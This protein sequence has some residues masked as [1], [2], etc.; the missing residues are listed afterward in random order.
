MIV[1]LYIVLV[2]LVLRFSV[3]LFNFMSNPKLGNYKRKFTDKVSIIIRV[4]EHREE[5]KVL[6][7]SI[8]DQDYENIEILVEYPGSGEKSVAKA[9][10][11]YFLFLDPDT[12]LKDGFIHSLV[13]RT[14]IFNLALLSIVP[15]R[16]MSGFLAFCTYPIGDFVLLNLFPLRLVRL[17]NQPAF[18]AADEACL[19]FEARIYRKYE[20]HQQLKGLG[21]PAMEIVRL[22]KQEQLKAELLL[23]NRLIYI[24]EKAVKTHLVLFSKNLMQNFGHYPMVALIY[25]VLLIGGPIAMMVEF[26]FEPAF[27]VL[28]FGLIFLSRVMTSF[29]A[30]QDPVK[31]ILLHP[32]QMLTL[33]ILVL[34]NTWNRIWSAVRHK[35]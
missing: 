33:T 32:L 2:F 17:I 19:F 31:N 14:K 25:L 13:Y 4:N 34:S 11:D 23:G 1:F 6:L 20:W 10:G 35:K 18:A 28:P 21:S 27:F 30:S 9:N 8:A 24:K 3:T 5:A 29:L 15:T 7:D 22:V 26:E 12:L 16:Q